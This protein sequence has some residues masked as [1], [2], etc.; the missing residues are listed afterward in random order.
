MADSDTIQTFYSAFKNGDAATMASLYH[1]DAEFRDPAFGVLKGSEVKMMWKMLIERSQGNL[2][3]DFTILEAT[4]STAVVKWEAR[5]P[6]SQTKRTIHNKITACLTLENGKIKTHSDHFNLWKWSRQAFGL[7]GF[8]I[9]WTP[10]FKSQ[11]QKT[12][13]KL[14]KAYMK[15]HA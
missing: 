14:L 11:L 4:G 6:F 3:I 10:F 1:D 15:Q 12:T 9:G 13:R 8:F 5:Y 2:E 7:K